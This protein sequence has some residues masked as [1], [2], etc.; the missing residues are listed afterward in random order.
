KTS[1]PCWAPPCTKSE[2][3]RAGG[4]TGAGG[5]RV[6]SVHFGWSDPARKTDPRCVLG[7]TLCRTPRGGRASGS[8]CIVAVPRS[9]LKEVSCGSHRG[10][11]LRPGR[12]SGVGGRLR[13]CGGS[14]PQTAQGSADDRH[15]ATGPRGVGCLAR[16]AALHAGGHGEYRGVLDANL[17]SARGTV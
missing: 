9:L 12:A 8:V 5:D 3:R 4:D 10:E 16:R 14:W 15:N 2:K 11:M 7:S 13:A 17:Y 1:S 6:R